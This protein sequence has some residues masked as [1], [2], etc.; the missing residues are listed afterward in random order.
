MGGG[1]SQVLIN[2]VVVDY[3]CL[4]AVTFGRERL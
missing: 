4:G 3:W 2:C 1:C